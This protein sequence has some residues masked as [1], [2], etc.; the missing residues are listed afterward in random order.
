[1]CEVREKVW[2]GKE[3]VVCWGEMMGR[4]WDAVEEVERG[5]P[6]L[7]LPKMMGV[8]S[9]PNLVERRTSA[10]PVWT[11]GSEAEI[12]LLCDSDGQVVDVRQPEVGRVGDATVLVLLRTLA[13]VGPTP[14]PLPLPHVLPCSAVSRVKWHY[15]TL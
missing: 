3:E 5:L 15:S 4:M 2:E 13:V 6:H 14:L 11:R 1:M 7:L 9:G 10:L 8:V 12:W